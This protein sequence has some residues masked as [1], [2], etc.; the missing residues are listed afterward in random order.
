MNPAPDSRRI[1]LIGATGVFGERLARMIVRWPDVTLVLAARR[2]EP[3]RALAARLDGPAVVET[4]VLDRTRPE[5][6]AA[7]AP[8]A[9]VDAAGPFQASDYRM[10]LAA[11]AAG[12]HYVDLADGRAFVAG[13]ED[14]V[15]PPPGLTAATGASSTP[16]LSQAALDKITAGWT[17]IDDVAAA[18]SP[19][20]RVPRGR[21]AMA[22]ILA[23]TGQPVRVFE[24][25]RWSVRPGWSGPVALRFP[26]IGVRW[27]VLAEVPDLDVMPARQ[28]PRRSAVFRAG[29]ES[30]VGVWGLWLLAWLVR[31]RIIR[32][33]TS[34]T[35]L[36]WR[37]TSLLTIGAADLGGMVVQASGVDAEGRPVLARWSLRAEPGEGPN[38]PAA[39][40]A[41]V[42]RGLL[43]GRPGPPDLAAILD[44]L[45]FN[46]VRTRLDVS[47]IGGQGLTPRTLGPTFERLPAEV[48]KFHAGLEPVRAVGTT[49]AYGSPGPAALV[50]RL[51]GLP[52]NGRHPAVVEMI[53]QGDGEAWIRRFG[54]GRFASVIRP[55]PDD[56]GAFE[57]R[58]GPIAF[59]IRLD[60]DAA[61]FTWRLDGWRLGPLPLP[62]RW[63]PIVR[64]RSFERG[65]VYRFRVMVAHPWLGVIFAYAG[66]LF[67]EG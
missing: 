65:G 54:S 2:L 3:L 15:T 33:L 1:L 56:P 62:R 22:A 52:A 23:W 45:R 13:F 24:A 49:V 41:A 36:L 43:D 29:V 8:W 7:L 21:S 37:L 32:T 28:T 60:P 35:P 61:G 38:V 17:R 58:A 16:T 53:P 26:F 64:A 19:G 27:V 34:L 4:A 48:R 14:A 67:A 10:P 46:A 12:A 50:R 31:L 59:R 9:V 11:L 42:L 5:G 30:P 57:E 63:S 51:L 47:W 55:L 44:E 25:G 20:G 66:R 18:I 6:L 40:A 39:P